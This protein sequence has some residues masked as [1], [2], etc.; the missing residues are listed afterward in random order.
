[1]SEVFLKPLLKTNDFDRTF[2]IGH[3]WDQIM[4]YKLS[5]ARLIELIKHELII[6][7]TLR[8]YEHHSFVLINN[9]KA[10]FDDV[11]NSSIRLE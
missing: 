8:F 9:G 3:R 2:L 6:P 7:N 11:K 1:M 10:S 5:A 4:K